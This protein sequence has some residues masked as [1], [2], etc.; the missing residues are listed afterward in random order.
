L[1]AGILVIVV[2]PD[3]DFRRSL[4]FA[5]ESEGFV[6]E[7]HTSISKAFASPRA[8]KAD[9]L[10]VDDAAV[11]DWRIVSEDFRHFG[12]PVV[13]LVGRVRAGPTLPL[14]TVLTKP[15]LGMPLIEAVRNLSAGAN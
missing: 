14:T 6:V 10:V 7:A 4:E 13:L 15:F 5:L 12:K 2:A 1:T 3:K 11:G 9:C 8:K